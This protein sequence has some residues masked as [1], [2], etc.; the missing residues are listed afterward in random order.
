[1]PIEPAIF[2][3]QDGRSQRGRNFFQRNPMEPAHPGIDP[4]FV[5]YTAVAVEQESL[6]RREGST[7]LLKR[8]NASLREAQEREDTQDAACC[9]QNRATTQN[10]MPVRISLRI[11]RLAWRLPEAA[12]KPQPASF[13]CRTFGARRVWPF[14]IPTLRSGLLTAASSRLAQNSLPSLRIDRVANEPGAKRR[15][16]VATRV[17]AWFRWTNRTEA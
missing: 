1:M 6:R 7:H 14:S 3:L 10:S 16:E 2:G 9:D 11:C 15:Q 8:R 12:K 17:S 4:H 13:L 5:D